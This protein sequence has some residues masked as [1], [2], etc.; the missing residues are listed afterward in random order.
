MTFLLRTSNTPSNVRWPCLPMTP[1]QGVP[2]LRVPATHNLALVTDS[3]EV[4]PLLG[5]FAVYGFRRVA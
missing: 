1:T 2:H 5:R 3:E 4:E